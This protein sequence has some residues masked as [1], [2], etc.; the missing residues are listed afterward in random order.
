MIDSDYYKKYKGPNLT[1]AQ[2]WKHGEEKLE[3]TEY[4]KEFY[5][6]DNNWNGKLYTY[7][8]IF[9]HRDY[10]YKFRIEFCGDSGRRH[11][12]HGMVGKP[13]H[14]FNPQQAMALGTFL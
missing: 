13:E 9:P 8:D 4:L 5:G 11:W 1:L 10:K 3:I 12:F 7:N 14:F 6:H 2:I